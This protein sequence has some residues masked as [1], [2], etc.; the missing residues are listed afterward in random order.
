ML[1][2][3]GQRLEVADELQVPRT[4]LE[5]KLTGIWRKVLGLARVGMHDNFFELGGHSLLATQVMSRVRSAFGV[6]VPLRL[7]FKN[8]TIEGLARAIEAASVEG[9]APHVGAD[10]DGGHID[11][12]PSPSGPD[13]PASFAQQRLW[14]LDQIDPGQAVYIIDYA[15]RI[16]GPLDVTVLERAVNEILRRHD[17]LRTTI[18]T[19]NGEPVQVVGETLTMRLPLIDISDEP[20]TV[21]EARARTLAATAPISRLI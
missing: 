3:P 9:I 19:R 6:V 15:L 21:R 12:A 7:F 13:V 20:T 18:A 2:L 8:P 16:T 11:D 4:K 17:S 10:T 14:F 1:A 5:E